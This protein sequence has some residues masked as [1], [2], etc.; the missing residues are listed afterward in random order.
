[1]TLP[2]F[3]RAKSGQYWL[4]NVCQ[5]FFSKYS[6]CR[7]QR[8]WSLDEMSNETDMGPIR[9]GMSNRFSMPFW[10]SRSMRLCVTPRDIAYYE[11]IIEE[12]LHGMASMSSSGSLSSLANPMAAGGLEGDTGG[13]VATPSYDSE[14][15]ALD[16]IAV[17]I[18]SDKFLSNQRFP[19][20]DKH[21]YG[22]HSDDGAI[23]HGRG[24]QLAPYGPK[25]GAGD[26]VGCG[27]DY[28]RGEIF[29]TLN[30]SF[31]GV[32]FSELT[33][34]E[35]RPTIGLDAHVNIVV[36]F[37]RTPFKFDLARHMRVMRGRNSIA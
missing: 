18:A 12:P 28:A 10:D 22:Y 8:A 23:F 24:R 20:W 37:G 4:F 3:Q 13:D 25:F 36:N 11:V 19:G 26:V 31:L 17:G 30:G 6:E 35:Y 29:F 1:M 5:F 33:Q 9:I 32:A 16:C 15:R 7:R 34:A 2:L 14:D 21:S 27:V